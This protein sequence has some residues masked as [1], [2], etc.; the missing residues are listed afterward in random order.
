[1]IESYKYE[2]MLYGIKDIKEVEKM[3]CPRCGKEIDEL[4]WE[5]GESRDYGFDDVAWLE[6]SCTCPHCEDDFAWIME[7]EFVREYVE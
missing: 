7:Y 5:I 2:L 1:M 3:K 6:F 4:P